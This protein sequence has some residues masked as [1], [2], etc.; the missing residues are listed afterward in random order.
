[1]RLLVLLALI[2]S[3]QVLAGETFLFEMPDPR[4]RIVVPDIPQVKMGVHP[5]KPVQP[6]ALFFGS[7]GSEYTISVLMPTSD[8][9]MTARDCARASARGVISRYGLD[10]KFVVTLQPSETTFVILFPYRVDTF[11][12]FKA[13]LFSSYRGTHCIDVHVSRTM[14][15]VAEKALAED[16]AKW[17]QGFR[18]AKIETY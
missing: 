14:T 12:Q 11:V 9:G 10:P 17:F 6:H 18:A 13:F 4:L 8:P 16:L 7:N 1:V 3:R 15:P 2:V 5:N